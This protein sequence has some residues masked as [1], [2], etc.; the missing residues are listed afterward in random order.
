MT[1]MLMTEEAVKEFLHIKDFRNIRK[2]DVIQMVSNLHRMNPVV[3]I[4]CIEQFPNFANNARIMVHDLTES[5]NKAIAAGSEESKIILDSYLKILEKLTDML[6]D[7]DIS[8]EEQ[9]II[10]HNIVYIG[11]EIRTH[12]QLAAKERLD[13]VKMVGGYV[14][15]VLSILAAALG[16]GVAIKGNSQHSVE[17]H[18]DELD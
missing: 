17:K 9:S 16:A 8:A 12:K 2:G 1:D 7:K 15:G 5:C 14:L 13:I 3:A 10:S 11:Q 6:T 4:K 18:D